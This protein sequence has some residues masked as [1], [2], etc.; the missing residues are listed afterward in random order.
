M[1]SIRRGQ[2]VGH[3][4]LNRKGCLEEDLWTSGSTRA[5]AQKNTGLSKDEIGPRLSDT[6]ERKRISSSNDEQI[7]GLIKAAEA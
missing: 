3:H 7:C 6:P 4:Y 2:I 5:T 1:F